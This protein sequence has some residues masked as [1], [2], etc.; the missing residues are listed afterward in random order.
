LSED[1]PQEP[2]GPQY[3]RFTREEAVAS[4]RDL[5][6]EVARVVP[7]FGPSTPQGVFLYKFHHK[8]LKYLDRLTK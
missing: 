3:E 1:S 8:M 6:C 7:R 2:E 4:F 5:L